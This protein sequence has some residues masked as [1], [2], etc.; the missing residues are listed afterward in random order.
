MTALHRG[1]NPISPDSEPVALDGG[2]ARR[3][4][5]MVLEPLGLGSDAGGGHRAFGGMCCESLG[6]PPVG[7]ES[8]TAN[9]RIAWLPIARLSGLNGADD[10]IRFDAVPKHRMNQLRNRRDWH[11]VM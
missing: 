11:H 2:L 3:G 9:L 4:D 6:Q 7:G 1:Q 5:P 10:G 8:R